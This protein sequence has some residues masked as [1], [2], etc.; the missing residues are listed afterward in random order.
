M[1]VGNQQIPLRAPPASKRHQRGRTR[2]AEIGHARGAE[3]VFE[4]GRREFVNGSVAAN[5][6]LNPQVEPVVE[7]K[8][9]LMAPNLVVGKGINVIHHHGDRTDQCVLPLCLEAVN[10]GGVRSGQPEDVALFPAEQR[11]S[12]RVEKV[13]AAGL[14]L[15]R[16]HQR[17]E[18]TSWSVDHAFATL[19][20]GQVLLGNE[21]LLEGHG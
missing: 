13:R 4:T 18:A 2:C 16:Q 12:R 17:V 14:L 10:R 20:C 19:R 6:H 8:S 15:G 3:H 7:Q 21:P 5:N 9:E 1:P 11:L